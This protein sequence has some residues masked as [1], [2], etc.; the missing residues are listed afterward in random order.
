MFIYPIHYSKIQHVLSR[1]Y[2]KLN[3]IVLNLISNLILSQMSTHCLEKTRKTY[4][5]KGYALMK[6]ISVLVR[7]QI[8]SSDH[9]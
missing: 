8:S 7:V 2:L 5:Y 9:N 6:L 4:I 3:Q 1:W